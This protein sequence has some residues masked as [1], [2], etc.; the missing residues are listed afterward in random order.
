[1][2]L[3]DDIESEISSAIVAGDSDALRST[4]ESFGLTG[5]EDLGAWLALAAHLGELDAMR[6]LLDFGAR[7]QWKNDEGETAFSFACACDQFDAAK[8]LHKHGADINSVDS[9]D[10]TPLDWAVRHARP[11]FRDWLKQVGGTRNMDYDEWPWPP[12]MTSGGT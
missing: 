12:P 11:A 1:M 10:G 2:T 6:I 7:V 9:S 8:L 3:P 5:H 4:I